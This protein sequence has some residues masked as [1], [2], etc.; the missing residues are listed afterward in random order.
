MRPF[1]EKLVHLLNTTPGWTVLQPSQYHNN[2]SVVL[3]RILS[4][5]TG[6]ALYLGY[7]PGVN[8][9]FEVNNLRVLLDP[10]E[11]AAMRAAAL[12]YI[13]KEGPDFKFADDR[14]ADELTK[15]EAALANQEND[16]TKRKY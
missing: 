11:S 12:R 14:I 5:H 13:K 6:V 15:L 16:T 2:A 8:D 3:L 7:W 1:V 9:G 10:Q 4:A